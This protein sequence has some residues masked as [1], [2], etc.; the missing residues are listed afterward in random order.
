MSLTLLALRQ[1]GLFRPLDLDHDPVLDD[2][3]DRTVPKAPEGVIDPVEGGVP[4]S[5]SPGLGGRG[6]VFRR[7]GG[8][9]AAQGWGRLM[10]GAEGEASDDIFR[11]GQKH[12]DVARRDRHRFA[13]LEAELAG[14]R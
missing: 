8:G 10:S 6:I 3:Q 12:T 14:R 13:R 11:V 4:G 5:G 7:N 1:A 9:L 2:R